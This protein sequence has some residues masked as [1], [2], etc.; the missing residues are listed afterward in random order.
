M[1]DPREAELPDGYFF[2]D[3]GD[4]NVRG[5]RIAVIERKEFPS[6]ALAL[7]AKAPKVK[8]TW[9]AN[10]EVRSGELA[11]VDVTGK[12]FWFKDKQT[13]IA[14][15]ARGLQEALEMEVGDD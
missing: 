14:A 3:N 12:P 1:T 11:L 15:L 10:W 13:A 5:D 2:T 6:F 9:D 8:M 4:L 7:L